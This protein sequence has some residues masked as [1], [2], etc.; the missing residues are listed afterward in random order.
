MSTDTKALEIRKQSSF[1]LV[2]AEKLKIM[3]GVKIKSPLWW[4]FRSAIQSVMRP[5][6]RTKENQ[7]FCALSLRKPQFR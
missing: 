4:S 2:A 3:E 6:H 1:V 7:V 5:G